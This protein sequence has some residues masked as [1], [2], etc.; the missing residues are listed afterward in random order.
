MQEYTVKEVEQFA[1]SKQESKIEEMSKNVVSTE[2]NVPFVE[3]KLTKV[4]D[5]KTVVVDSSSQ[6]NKLTNNLLEDYKEEMNIE[7]TTKSNISN[8]IKPEKNEIAKE[9]KVSNL[10]SQMKPR[11]NGITKEEKNAVNAKKQAENR[12]RC[13]VEYI[14][15]KS[16]H[17]RKCC[18]NRPNFQ[19]KPLQRN[20]CPSNNQAPKTIKKQSPSISTLYSEFL[21]HC[22]NIR[23]LLHLF[24]NILLLK[25]LNRIRGTRSYANIKKKIETSYNG[26]VKQK[27]K[28]E[29]PQSVE[30]IAEF[31]L[32]RL[33]K[34][35]EDFVEKQTG[36]NLI[37][38]DLQPYLQHDLENCNENSEQTSTI[39][40]LD[41]S[42]HTAKHTCKCYKNHISS[43]IT[44]KKVRKMLENYEKMISSDTM[45]DNELCEN[46]CCTK[47]ESEATA[48]ENFNEKDVVC[49]DD[50]YDCECKF[51]DVDFFQ[52]LDKCD[53]MVAKTDNNVAF[54]TNEC[55]IIKTQAD[56]LNT[57]LDVNNILDALVYEALNNIRQSYQETVSESYSNDEQNHADDEQSSDS[58]SESKKS[59][60]VYRKAPKSENMNYLLLFGRSKSQLKR[61]DVHCYHST[62]Q[63]VLARKGLMSKQEPEK[64]HV[65]GVIKHYR[66]LQ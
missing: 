59:S 61:R 65:D 31:S 5:E 3:K 20:L 29:K 6:E 24:Q 32:K 54:C 1:K 37:K 57:A 16:P 18:V 41:E 17:T 12:N 9:E 48:Q 35:E 46:L 64:A 62:E 53:Q 58:E 40:Q 28:S 30:S 26:I 47:Q 10:S 44:N 13:N 33:F 45:K 38:Q 51:R 22:P 11:K 14:N 52:T 21:L 34:D 2:A 15:R 60:T 25:M 27:Q 49:L 56:D 8:V 42:Q 43:E 63:Q 7:N 4:E 23:T 39:S 55:T 50:L 66:I 19:R 36:T